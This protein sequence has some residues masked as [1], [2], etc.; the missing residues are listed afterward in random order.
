MHTPSD[1]MGDLSVPCYKPNCD[2]I[3]PDAPAANI[4][5]HQKTPFQPKLLLP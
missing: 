4:L 1:K 2:L 3:K 5:P